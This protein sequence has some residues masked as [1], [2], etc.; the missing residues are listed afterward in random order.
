MKEIREYDKTNDCWVVG[1][2][3]DDE[4]IL[5]ERQEFQDK[6]GMTC[7]EWI[8]KYYDD[9]DGELRYGLIGGSVIEA[10]NIFWKARFLRDGLNLENEDENQKATS[11]S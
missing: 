2:E 8:E 5:R 7:E 9:L 3:Y 11:A 4:D 10:E 1:Y 6:W